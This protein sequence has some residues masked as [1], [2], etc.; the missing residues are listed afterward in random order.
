MLLYRIFIQKAIGT[1]KCFLKNFAKGSGGQWRTGSEEDWEGGWKSIWEDN[2][3]EKKAEGSKEC[4]KRRKKTRGKAEK[5]AKGEAARD[6]GKGSVWG[7]QMERVP[8]DREMRE[9]V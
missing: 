8:I 1:D 3:Q 6:G 5:I 7:F 2:L 9:K 4:K